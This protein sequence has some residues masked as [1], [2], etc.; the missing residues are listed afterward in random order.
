MLSFSN[1]ICLDNV[2]GRDTTFYVRKQEI[3]GQTISSVTVDDQHDPYQLQDGFLN[4]NLLVPKGETRCAAVQY[5]NDLKL[6]SIGIAHDSRVDISS[7]W[8]RTSGI[9]IYRKT[10][11]GVPSF[12]STMSSRKSRPRY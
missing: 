6:A 7:A 9:S 10:L 5:K 8:R 3:G 2:A 1:N 4:F 12:V 11:W